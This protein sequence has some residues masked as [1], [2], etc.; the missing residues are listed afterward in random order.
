M[1]TG[2]GDDTYQFKDIRAN[3]SS[4]IYAHADTTA[5]Q[6]FLCR[7]VSA[8]GEYPE[9]EAYSLERAIARRYH[10][11]ED[12]VLVTNGATDA[13]Y[14][15]AQALSKTGVRCF[16]RFKPTFSE[17]ADACRMFGIEETE[18]GDTTEGNHT[19]FWVCNPNN[20]TGKVYDPQVL[21]HLIR[22][23]AWVV[24]DQSYEDYTLAQVMTHQEG[25]GC[26][27]VIQLHSLTK[28]Y[29]IPGLRVGYV[30][31]A[32]AV[33]EML[34]RFLRPWSVNSLAIKAGIFLTDNHIEVVPDLRGYLNETQNLLHALRGV[35]G[36]EAEATQTN[37]MLAR[38]WH[39]KAAALKRILAEQHH[40][41]IRDASNF[42]GLDDSYFR[43]ATQTPEENALLIQA[44]RQC[45]P[46][47]LK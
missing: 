21:G 9:P 22:Q 13:I 47:L 36:V 24:I 11:G 29:A 33:I 43:I 40:I 41:L 44:L 39:I 27:N 4:N 26:E 16:C 46:L 1:L 17:Y 7:H 37:F 6:D 42:E 32:P 35:G 14:L 45:I 8:I 20:P 18:P 5:L 15:V 19:M 12:C 2:H 31:A 34:R 23:Y 10:I 30:T 25:V 3:F 38:A 28:K